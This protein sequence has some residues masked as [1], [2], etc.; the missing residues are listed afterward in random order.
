MKLIKNK[1]IYSLSKYILLNN[2][3]VIRIVLALDTSLTLQVSHLDFHFLQSNPAF[4]PE[5]NPFIH[6][7]FFNSFL[8]FLSKSKNK[9]K[10]KINK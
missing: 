7:P 1:T 5:K 8:K 6:L 3:D 4:Y 9:P 10:N 2:D